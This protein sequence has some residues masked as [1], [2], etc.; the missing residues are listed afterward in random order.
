MK[1]LVNGGLNLSELDGWWEEA[2]SPDVG[3]GVNGGAD[4]G[5]PADDEREAELLY[6]LL[7][8]EVVAEFYRRD[9]GG[10]P[11]QWIARLRA[12]MTRLTPQFST[13]RMLLQY[14]RE[15]YLP[16]AADYARRCADGAALAQELWQWERRLHHR[17]Q[18]V[19][20]GRLEAVSD[21]DGSTFSLPVYLGDIPLDAVAAQLYA[22][23]SGGEPGLLLPMQPAEPVPG[24]INGVM[25]RAKVGTRRP[26]A[27]FTARLVPQHPHAKVPLEAN[28]IRW[29]DG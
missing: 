24:A 20:S 7:E 12:S 29:I 15:Y 5:G 27:D 18:E 6:H 13:N 19:H 1:V 26:A 21:A 25:F 17:W 2:Y 22:E 28:R 9:A 8:E 3:W 14:V 10:L 4:I 23:A 11:R 16:A